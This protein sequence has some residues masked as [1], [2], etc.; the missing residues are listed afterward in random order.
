MLYMLHDV[1]IVQQNERAIRGQ[2]KTYGYMVTGW[3]T[4]AGGCQWSAY[5]W[6]MM[7]YRDAKAKGDVQ[8]AAD[9]VGAT[10]RRG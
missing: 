9:A 2:T 3:A 8:G 5:G 7:V 4:A 10:S 6:N 1:Y